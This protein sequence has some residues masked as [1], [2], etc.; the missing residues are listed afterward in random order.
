MAVANTEFTILNS[1]STYRIPGDWTPAQIVANYSAQFPGIS[2]MIAEETV[3]T[4][5][6]GEVKVITFKPRTGT[7]G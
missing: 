2:N 3:E 4:R 6:D 1:D 5:A 7:K